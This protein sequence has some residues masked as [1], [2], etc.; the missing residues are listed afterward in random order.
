M[1][2]SMPE[3]DRCA[4]RVDQPF[5]NG[6]S[7]FTV[8]TDTMPDPHGPHARHQAE[9][10]EWTREF[11]ENALPRPEFVG[12]HMCGIIDTSSEMRGKE[13]NQHQ[14]LMTTGGVFYPEMERAVRGLSAR[15][16]TMALGDAGDG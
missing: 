11:M 15:L 16:Y 10:A 12:W 3:L 4:P 2:E 5:L 1:A 14:G 6:D 9:R 7:A 8:P 13:R